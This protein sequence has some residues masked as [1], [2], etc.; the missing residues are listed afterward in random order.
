MTFLDIIDISWKTGK[1]PK[2]WKTSIISPIL[3]PGK[4]AEECKSYRPIALTSILC[5]IME[6]MIHRRL[7]NWIIENNII[8]NFQTAYQP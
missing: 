8:E 2:V 4:P 7:M 1:V 6:K 3:K 5:K